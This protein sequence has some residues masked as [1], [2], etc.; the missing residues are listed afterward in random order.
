MVTPNNT[1]LLPAEFAASKPGE[2][3][4]F[5][6]RSYGQ[7]YGCAPAI[8]L[9][10]L[11]REL[12]GSA[13]VIVPTVAEAES[14]ESQLAFF[15]AQQSNNCLLVDSETLPYDSFSP[16]QDLVSRRLSVLASLLNE[17]NSFCIVAAP[18]LF[19]RLPPRAY[20]RNFSLQLTTGEDKGLSELQSQLTTNGYE[21][22]SQVSQHGE[23][24]V[25]GSLI[26]LYPMGSERPVRID[27]FD[28]EI[29]SIRFFDPDTQ[30]SSEPIARLDMLPARDFPTD[31][32]AIREFRTRFRE[33]FEGNPGNSLI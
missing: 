27:F 12:T 23:F 21:R 33:R 31:Q 4:A 11:Q 19:Y 13:V 17:R 32:E 28:D 7:A 9:A 20:I 18:T 1:F 2:T 15:S 26:D 6:H 3:P 10:E 5:K 25:R 14:L 22:V 8:L 24:A 29:E 16:H 30:V